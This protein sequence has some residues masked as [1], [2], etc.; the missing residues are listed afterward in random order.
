[1]HQIARVL[2]YSVRV[3]SDPAHE[4]SFINIDQPFLHYVKKSHLQVPRREKL[5]GSK[6]RVRSTEM[7]FLPLERK[8]RERDFVERDD[9]FC[10]VIRFFF[11]FSLT[12]G[13]RWVTEVN[14]KDHK[15]VKCHFL[16]Y[17]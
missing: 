14:G 13:E 4:V 2:L 3:N 8:Q 9:V 12:V 7:R 15:W 6:L 16:N 11:F 5:M 10:F 1:V 17:K